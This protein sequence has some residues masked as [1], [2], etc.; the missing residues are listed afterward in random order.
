MLAAR[1]AA[2]CDAITLA[3]IACAAATRGFAARSFDGRCGGAARH[4][5]SG[6]RSGLHFALV[7][8]PNR[9]Y[10]YKVAKQRFRCEL[11]LLMDL[12]V[13]LR[14]MMLLLM[15]RLCLSGQSL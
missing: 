5:C 11:L 13:L 2:T 6:P 9:R 14:L 12:M 1:A 4:D 7:A 3:V 15:L 8:L 10:P